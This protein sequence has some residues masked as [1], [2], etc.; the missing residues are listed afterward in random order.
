[1]N[2]LHIAN[3][4]A[5]SKV[6]SNLVK[7]L[8]EMGFNQTVYCPVRTKWELGGNKFDARNTK[9]VYNCC[10]KPWYK[11]VYHYKAKVLYRDMKKRIDLSQFNIIHAPTLF[12]DGALAYKAY[13]EYGTPYVIAVRSADTCDFIGRG[14]YHTWSLGRKIVLNAKQIYFISVAGKTQFENSKFARPILHE[15]KDRCIVRPNGIDDV[16]L[17]NIIPAVQPSR[18]ICYVGT[19]L[20]RKNV[21]RLIN[22]VSS[23]RQ[24]EGYGDVTLNIIGGGD[25]QNGAVKNLIERNSHFIEY[26]GRITDK[27]ELIQKMRQSAMFAMPSWTE[28]FGLVYVEALTQGLPVVYSKNDGIDGFFDS[29]V[30][31]AVNPFSESDILHAIKTI[32]D[33]PHSYGNSKVDFNTFNWHKIS[34]NYAADYIRICGDCE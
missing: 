15:I 1:M 32:L 27:Q 23:L 28:T 13:K 6:H 26:S 29:S 4:F 11:F 12:S 24:K 2:I 16:W 33:H 19:F 3:G 18:K 9:F 7:R 21:T 5:R 22:A 30:G 10:I 34:S 17:Q 31:I 14:M 8:D 20:P 25:D